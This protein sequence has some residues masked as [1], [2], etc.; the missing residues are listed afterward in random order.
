QIPLEARI[1][2]CCDTWNAM[3]TDRP[4]RKALS[5]DIAIAELVSNAGGQFDPRVVNVLLEIVASE[6]AAVRQ[7]NPDVTGAPQPRLEYGYARPAC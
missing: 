4:Y 5:H 1:I 6:T 2:T 7:V 3:R